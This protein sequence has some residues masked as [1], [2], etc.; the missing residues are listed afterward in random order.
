MTTAPDALLAIDARIAKL[1]KLEENWNG[2]HA[3]PIDPATLERAKPFA[4]AL[5]EAGE[6][7]FICPQSD[8]GVDVSDNDTHIS[9]ELR[10]DGTATLLLENLTDQD[11]L[12]LFALARP[13]PPSDAM[14]E[15]A[16]DA[17]VARTLKQM[18][19]KS[20]GSFDKADDLAAIAA[21]QP[22][23]ASEPRQ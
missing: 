8:G 13:S 20:W 19:E 10:P 18:S 21:M 22:T 23:Q 12:R 6:P 5:I 11:A 16:Y 7:Q 2:Y 4:L 17:G 15:A 3:K 1:S 9:F 14:L